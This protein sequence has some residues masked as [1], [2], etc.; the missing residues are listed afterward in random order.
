MKKKKCQTGGP[1][2]IDSTQLMQRYSTATN[3]P[4]VNAVISP[5]FLVRQEE[6]RKQATIDSL[7]NLMIPAG[8][9]YQPSE[10]S[11]VKSKIQP[12]NWKNFQSGGNIQKLGNISFDSDKATQG[13]GYLNVVDLKSRLPYK[14]IRND[15][16]SYRFYQENPTPQV[17]SSGLKDSVDVSIPDALITAVRLFDVDKAKTLKKAQPIVKELSRLSYNRKNGAL[18]AKELALREK[19]SKQIDPYSYR[20]E[21]ALEGFSNNREARVI[22]PERIPYLRNY[23]GLPNEMQ[24]SSY[25]LNK[26]KVYYKP[27]V[28]NMDTQEYTSKLIYDRYM[29]INPRD[30]DLGPSKANMVVTRPYGRGA[31]NF[32]PLGKYTVG[33]GIDDKG[34]YISIYDKW[35][36]EP[37]TYPST[38]S[39]APNINDLNNPFEVYDRIYLNELSAPERDSVLMQDSKLGIIP[40]D[41]RNKKQYG[42]DI[43]SALGYRDDSPFKNEP[44]LNINSNNISMENVSKPLI[45]ISNTGDT[46]LM[47]PN[48]KYKFKGNQVTEIPAYDMG[49]ILQ[50]LTSALGIINPAIGIAGA[51]LPLVSQLFSKPDRTIVSGSP[52]S[53]QSGGDIQLSSNAF[54]VKGNPNVTDGN[55]YNYGGTPIALDHNEVV[56]NNFV[57]SEDLTNPLTKESYASMAKLYEKAKGKAEKKLKRTPYD[58]QAKATVNYSEQSLDSL[59]KQ[60]ETQAT[61]MGLRDNSNS[62]Q[63][64]GDIHIN[65]KNKGKFTA[66]ASRAGMGVQEFASHVLA[67]KEDYSSTQVKR[68]NFAKNASHWKHQTGGPIYMGV[69]QNNPDIFYDPYNSKFL[70]RQFSGSYLPFTGNTEG[71]MPSQQAISAHLK[72]YPG[73][74]DLSKNLSSALRFINPVVGTLAEGAQQLYKPSPVQPVSPT[75]SSSPSQGIWDNALVGAVSPK[76]DNP[77]STPVTSPTVKPKSSGKAKTVTT[78]VPTNTVS[79][80]PQ[81]I[82]DIYRNNMPFPTLPET[83]D[84]G[85][86]ISLTVKT[87]PGYGVLDYN[88]DWN[89]AMAGAAAVEAASNLPEDITSFNEDATFSKY[90]TPFTF[91][92]ALKGIELGAKAIGAFSPAEKEAQLLDNSTITQQSFDPTNSLYQNQRT[93][94]NYLNKLGAAPLNLRRALSNSALASKYNSEAQI[95]SQYDVMNK[96]AASQYQDRVS[97]RRRFNVASIART[98]DVNAANRA[99]RD[100]TQQNFF[101][102]VGQFGEDLNRKKY[103][104]DSINLML[105]MYPDVAKRFLKLYGK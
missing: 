53:Y 90:R 103:T 47:K 71:L 61:L 33:R 59:A 23:L 57:Y 25:R 7:Y 38:A 43:V 104:D 77:I 29:G 102:S 68:A 41:K 8:A 26:D 66:S 37:D 49:G 93:Y 74:S 65:P 21:T 75:Q 51:A 36:L 99:A 45:G 72:Q 24:Q 95:N 79:E 97:N 100:M 16:G 48:K 18:S 32:T 2:P 67:N 15:D 52:G 34:D 105:Q 30:V 42:G 20:S 85:P 78:P 88:K 40:V 82:R 56:S 98:N 27:Y 70:S 91:G 19:L 76:L 46:K 35:D 6:L 73:R 58:E 17:V 64:G 12:Y 92:D 22:A 11:K 87:L 101:T 1:L 89:A 69:S 94:S 31:L 9:T 81:D 39:L 50:G 80:T 3:Q 10:H 62:Y 60:Q 84:Q 63:S 5:D 44:Y 86:G 14:V 4:L 83:V 55:T 96:N 54:Q 28:K 13:K